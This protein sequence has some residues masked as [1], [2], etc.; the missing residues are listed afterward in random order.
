MEEFFNA[1]SL[2]MRLEKLLD[3]QDLAGAV[4]RFLAAKKDLAQHPGRQL[5]ALALATEL[6]GRLLAKAGDD[7]G[8]RAQDLRLADIGLEDYQF[9]LLSEWISGVE[10]AGQPPW[11][12]SLQAARLI[13]ENLGLSGILP[14]ESAASA[15]L[16]RALADSFHP[17]D[18]EQLLRL[19]AALAGCLRL[20]ETFSDLVLRL[21]FEKVERLGQRL[22][23][24]RQAIKVYCEG[25]IRGNLVFQLSRL[26]ALLTKEIRR[27]A[28]LSPWDVM[29]AGTARG[30]LVTAKNLAAVNRQAGEEVLVLLAEAEGDETVPEGVAGIILAHGL[31]H[32]SHLAIRTRQEGVVLIACEERPAIRELAKQ[33]GKSLLLKAD[34][35]AVTFTPAAK[36]SLKH[37]QRRKPSAVPGVELTARQPL[38]ELE[39]VS[40]SNGGAKAYGA[41]LLRTLARGSEAGFTT[42]RGVAVPFGVMEAALAG[43]A[44]IKDRYD[45]LVKSVTEL[46]GAALEARRE[47]LASLVADLAVPPELVRGVRAAFPQKARLMVRSSANSEDLE[48]MAG[49]GLYESVANVAP[50]KVAAAIRQVWASLWT[51]RATRSRRQAGIP[52]D[53]VHMAVLIQELIDPDYSFVMHTVNPI[54]G[55]KDE[56]YIEMAVG[57]GEVLA[58]AAIRG[59]P[60]RLV[61][62]KKSGAIRMLAFADF[63]VALR[64]ESGGGIRPV[65]VDYS[66]I[67]L[68]M[69]GEARRKLAGRLAAIGRFVEQAYGHPQD[70]EGAVKGE[71]IVLLQSRAQQ[72]V[73]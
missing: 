36:K 1:G 25:E 17:D 48:N 54:S 24:D 33:E 6:R 35:E 34:A 15:A 19:K 39:Q 53:A 37:R 21:F 11:K 65:P 62:D 72:G 52:Q 40:L 16:L 47:E 22:G 49:A 9:V 29:V 10:K 55:N 68:T 28:A 18:R 8:A 71:T 38:L 56:V 5:T 44:G 14:E 4:N 63:S 3:D 20:T 70:I 42:P 32:L 13:L 27:A 67:G 57:L 51:Q 12:Q 73:A 26:A 46:D 50:D 2:E 58:S 60:Y 41:Q 45:Q 66:Q 69:D 30:R 31:P 43:A 23:I 59:T 7:L 61:V 64:V